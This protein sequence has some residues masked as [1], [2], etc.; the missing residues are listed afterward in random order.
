[1]HWLMQL[2][3]LF[4]LALEQEITSLFG[5]VANASHGGSHVFVPQS[6]KML[7]SDWL[8]HRDK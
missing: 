3:I 5:L 2:Q 1:M 6:D 4:Y 7:I 8:K